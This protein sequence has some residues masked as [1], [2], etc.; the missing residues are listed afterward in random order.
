M[1]DR[2]WQ[3]INSSIRPRPAVERVRR[4]RIIFSRIC[5]PAHCYGLGRLRDQQRGCCASYSVARM[6][7]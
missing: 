4:R 5:L 3:P 6:V 7:P 2:A 1:A